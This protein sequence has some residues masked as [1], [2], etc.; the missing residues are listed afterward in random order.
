MNIDLQAKIKKIFKNLLFLFLKTIGIF[1]FI[2]A[3]GMWLCI[4]LD[5]FYPL[6]YKQYQKDQQPL[7]VVG[8]NGQLLHV[9]PLSDG[10]IRLSSQIPYGLSTLYLKMLKVSEDQRFDEHMGVDFLAIFRATWQMVSAQQIKSGASTLTMQ[11]IKL[12][13]PQKKSFSYK[14]IQAFR[15]W[16]LEKI[17]SKEEILEDY[18]QLIPMGGKY[19]GL[20]V[21]A[22]I[23]FDKDPYLLTPAEIALLIAIPK[24]PNRY[25][26]INQ[27]KRAKWARDI[28]LKQAF[29]KHLLTPREYET[30]QSTPLPTRIYPIPREIPHLMADLMKERKHELFKDL[31]LSQALQQAIQNA[32]YGH[33]QSQTKIAQDANK[34]KQEE[35]IKK[36]EKEEEDDQ[37]AR[38]W[39][40]DEQKSL[41]KNRHQL[42]KIQITLDEKLQKG[43]QNHLKQSLS[44]N[45]LKSKNKA[46]LIASLKTKEMLAYVGSSHFYEEALEGQNDMTLAF[47]SPG[48]TLKP[49]LYGLAFDQSMLHPQT[50][51][52]D[53]HTRLSQY[54]PGNFEQNFMG[55]LKA[56]ETLVM[57]LNTPSIRILAEYGVDAFLNKLKAQ[58]LQVK[59]QGYPGLSLILGGVSMR[60]WDLF[61]LYSTICHQGQIIQ[62]KIIDPQSS[63]AQIQSNEPHSE[64]PQLL[65]ELAQKW[66]PTILRRVPR[67][68]GSLDRLDVSYKTG[69]SYD[70]RDAWAIGCNA[71]YLV[72]VWSGRADGQPIA[73]QSGLLNS[74]PLLFDIFKLLPEVKGLG[75]IWDDA[76]I[77]LERFQNLSFLEDLVPTQ[78]RRIGFRGF[79]DKIYD[80]TALSESEKQSA[81]KGEFHPKAK[82]IW[83]LDWVK[84]YD[85]DPNLKDKVE[86][87][88]A[89]MAKA[90][91]EA[92]ED[93]AQDP[94]AYVKQKE[95]KTI[96]N[97]AKSYFQ[98]ISPAHGQIFYESHLKQ[99]IL[100]KVE[101][102]TRP[103]KWM[104][105]QKLLES[106]E[107]DRWFREVLWFPQSIGFY[108][109]GVFDDKN[110]YTTVEIEI[111]KDESFWQ[112]PKAKIIAQ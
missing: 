11:L 98:I 36:E 55:E 3:F 32:N 22:M 70:H 111:R 72:A 5:Q 90:S 38:L 40:L 42:E 96:K 37:S 28:I 24:N 31:H 56:W 57:S 64:P 84:R 107:E 33:Y 35:I 86:Q 34:N 60:L 1:V 83:D 67:P 109:I 76:P 23:Y 112:A 43:I 27:P 58:N 105:N 88:Q 66:L 65:G 29:E 91:D 53:Q 49:F 14:I 99:G 44:L 78:P 17:L 15:A 61:K 20:R 45:D 25:H 39:S 50:I 92:K 10:R 48:S 26:P 87:K 94:L 51:M 63:N 110:E 79:F 104:I 108:Q 2:Y 41:I 77:R 74:A 102:G 62:P 81:Q 82:T 80:W 12:L 7:E 9:I 6:D 69:T 93:D 18:L 52:T 73:E 30:A 13:D 75:E 97:A 54:A 16:Q 101:G 47:R 89:L 71:E 19:E 106:K 8:K 95:K 103:M 100:L 46:V 59:H 68:I 85:I 21:G 4:R